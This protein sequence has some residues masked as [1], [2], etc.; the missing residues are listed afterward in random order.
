MAAQNFHFFLTLSQGQMFRQVKVCICD[1]LQVTE[2]YSQCILDKNLLRMVT[3]STENH[4]LG[5]VKIFSSG[6]EKEAELF[7]SPWLP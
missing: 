6:R 2:R 4:S 3:L 1:L 5:L 7:L